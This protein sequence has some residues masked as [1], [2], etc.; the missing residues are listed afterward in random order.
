MERLATL[1]LWHR[2]FYA[3]LNVGTDDKHITTVDEGG[4][5][6]AAIQGLDEKLKAED[7]HKDAEIKALEKRLSDLEQLVETPPQK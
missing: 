7:A 3:A 4:V 1:G 5:A 6:L 2:I